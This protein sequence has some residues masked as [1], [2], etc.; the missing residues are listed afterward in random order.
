MLE[1]EYHLSEYPRP[2]IKIQTNHIRTIIEFQDG[3]KYLAHFNMPELA[4]KENW[5]EKFGVADPEIRWIEEKLEKIRSRPK[6]LVQTDEIQDGITL[7]R[8]DNIFFCF[9]EMIISTI[10]SAFNLE[11]DPMGYEGNP[12]IPNKSPVS[13]NQLDA[14]RQQIQPF[15][16]VA[17]S[18]LCL[19]RQIREIRRDLS[20]VAWKLSGSPDI[21]TRVRRGIR[22]H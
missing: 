8:N 19:S 14:F 2:Y 1:H 3:S 15:I 9:S 7:I 20:T 18:Y 22:P 21:D 17:Y 4:K 10:P 6:F 11:V 12:F 5:L 16:P 13:G